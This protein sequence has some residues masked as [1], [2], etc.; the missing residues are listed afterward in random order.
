MNWR[1]L[2]QAGRNRPAFLLNGNRLL[3]L[4]TAKKN[5]GHGVDFAAMMHYDKESSGCIRH[6]QHLLQSTDSGRFGKELN[7]QVKNRLI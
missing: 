5:F 1:C 6:G 3:G 7:Q 4:K 2:T